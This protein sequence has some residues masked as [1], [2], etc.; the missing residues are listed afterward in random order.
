MP[1]QVS[2]AA[3]AQKLKEQA[4]EDAIGLRASATPLPGPTRKAFSIVPEIRVGDFKVR[5]FLDGDIDNLEGMD[6]PFGKLI[7]AVMAGD[8]ENEKSFVPRGKWAWIL[9]WM[10]TR[11]IDEVDK[12]IAEGGIKAV[13]EAASKEFRKSTFG[14]LSGVVQAVIEQFNVYCAPVIGYG[15][16]DDK[17]EGENSPNPPSP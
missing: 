6:H 14:D 15:P 13:T 3:L 1:P 2:P 12:V 7:V 16:S 5:R 11:D 8:K 4:E 10:M 9:C 17:G